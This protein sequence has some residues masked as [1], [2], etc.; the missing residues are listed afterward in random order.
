MMRTLG[1]TPV[2][3]GQVCAPLSASLSGLSAHAEVR[4]LTSRAVERR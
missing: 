2:G 1:R 3:E 4:E